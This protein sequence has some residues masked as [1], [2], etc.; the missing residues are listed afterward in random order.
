MGLKV[1]KMK[2]ANKKNY[3]VILPALTYTLGPILGLILLPVITK[4]ISPS[5]YGEYTYYLTLINFILVFSLFPSLNSAIT[6]FLNTK[7]TDYQTDKI[8]FLP[9]IL[10]ALILFTLI[11]ASLLLVVDLPLMFAYVAGTYLSIN[12]V[13]LIKS[14]YRTNGDVIIFSKISIFSIISQYIIILFFYL[15]DIF[16]VYILILGLLTFNVFILIFFAFI[17]RNYFQRIFIF[18]KKEEYDKILKFV[19]PSIGIAFAG[20]VLSLG[21][22][23]IIKN[24][25]NEG[26]KYLG[27]YSVNYQVYAQSIEILTTVFFLYIPSLLYPIYE[28]KGLQLYLKAQKKILDLYIILGGFFVVFFML[29]HGKINFLLFDE[30]YLDQTKLSI[31]ILLG[32]F[33]FG[34]FRI[35]STYFAVINK[36]KV[37]NNIL[38]ITAILNIILNLIFIPIYGYQT[39]ALTTLIC[40]V[41]IFIYTNYIIKRT[42]K[43]NMIGSF[44][45]FIIT[46]LI[47][48]CIFIPLQDIH[49][50]GWKILLEITISFVLI[51]TIFLMAFFKRIKI[52]FKDLKEG[53]NL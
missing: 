53:K 47:T 49:E 14:Y 13:N 4:N 20:I 21:D 35:L 27:I 12:I 29:N 1:F 45:I 3:R 51:L 46:I 39:A 24:V 30:S 10:I 7:F 9:L 43:L 22:R 40:F 15:L 42:V 5:I 41:A 28:K 17:K 25:L 52:I 36:M 34:M 33:F 32:Q 18:R 48:G 31:Y 44:N 19:I 11:S 23:F 37:I 6:R 50:G 8:K 2:I 16:N 26:E 38:F